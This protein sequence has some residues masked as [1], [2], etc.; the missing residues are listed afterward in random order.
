MQVTNNSDGSVIITLVQAEKTLFLDILRKG[1]NI[2]TKAVSR[3]LAQFQDGSSPKTT[4]NF[5]NS[6][7]GQITP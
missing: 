4:L 7:N 3:D 2:L 5:A 1:I 6:L